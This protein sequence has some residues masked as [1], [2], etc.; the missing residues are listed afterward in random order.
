VDTRGIE[1]TLVNH[2]KTKTFS[3]RLL[4]MDWEVDDEDDFDVYL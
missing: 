2:W 1:P 4:P 3:Q